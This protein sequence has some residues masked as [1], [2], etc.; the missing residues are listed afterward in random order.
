MKQNKIIAI[1]GGIGSGK[2]SVLEIL[3]SLNKTV[4]SCDEIT[5]EL[6]GKR[7]VK[8]KI[9]ELFPSAVSGKIFLK[10]DKSVI[11]KAVFNDRENYEK[12]TRYLTPL[13]FSVAMTR[14]KKLANNGD[15]FVE[16]PV[17]FELKYDKHFEKIIVVKRKLEDRIG[18]V[19][20]RSNLTK[21]QVIERI[22]NQINYDETDFSNCVVIDND[23]DLE[24]LK[25]STLKAIEKI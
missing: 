9:K 13:I 10:V 20:S 2:S 7:L 6:Y 3:K 14:A 22:N 15:V 25:I 12:L 24:K 4:I 23:G 19:I 17:L 21:E 16:T 18:A 1:T 11:S 5:K 8:S